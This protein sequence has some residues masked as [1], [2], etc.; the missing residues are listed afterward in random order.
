MLYERFKGLM[1]ATS[2]QSRISVAGFLQNVTPLLDDI[3]LHRRSL[4]GMPWAKE[5]GRRTVASDN[6]S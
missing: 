3:R 5:T 1:A 4:S 6:A 2:S